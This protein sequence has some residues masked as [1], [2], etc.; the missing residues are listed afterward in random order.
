M[1]NGKV[2]NL[3]QVAFVVFA[4]I[5]AVE[6]FK[7]STRMNY[8]WFHCTPQLSTIPGTEITRAIAVG[9]PSCDKRGQ[10]KSITKRLT[11]TFDPNVEPLAFCI[12][13][14]DDIIVGYVSKINEEELLQQHCSNIIHLDDVA[15]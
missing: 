10:L 8:E 15:L 12:H 9:G 14:E 5:A 11:R 1:S 7:Y 6:Y 4:L 3:V 2:F 13:E